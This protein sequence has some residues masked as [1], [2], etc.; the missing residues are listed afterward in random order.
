MSSVRISCERRLLRFATRHQSVHVLEEHNVPFV[1]DKLTHPSTPPR[2]EEDI[3]VILLVMVA[4]DLLYGFG[5]FPAVIKGDTGAE[6]V[7]NVGLHMLVWDVSQGI[8]R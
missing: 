7:G 6:M 1:R 8:P 3:R 4:N 2:S 5:C